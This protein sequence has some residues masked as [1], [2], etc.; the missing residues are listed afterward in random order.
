MCY[1]WSADPEEASE[2]D[3]TS[4]EATTS[5]EEQAG[6]SEEDSLAA[7]YSDGDGMPTFLGTGGQGGEQGGSDA[8]V[9]LH[10]EEESYIADLESFHHSQPSRGG[11]V[12]VGLF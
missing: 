4:E 6:C 3:N 8:E 10:S 1:S 9:S 11:G 7:Y 12:K 2:H 5:D